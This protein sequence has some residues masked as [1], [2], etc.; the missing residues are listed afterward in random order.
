NYTGIV[1]LASL[2]AFPTLV[3]LSLEY[4]P[5]LSSLAGLESL[6]T[7]TDSLTITNNDALA[8]LLALAQL[9]EVGGDLILHENPGLADLG[10]LEQ[11]GSVGGKLELGG[12]GLFGG[13]V[14]SPTAKPIGTPAITSLAGLTSL[15]HVGGLLIAG[16]ELLVSLDGAPSLITV[17]E[18][19][20]GIHD[21]PMLPPAITQAFV[22]E[23]AVAGDIQVCDQE[24][25]E[26]CYWCISGNTPQ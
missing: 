20:V 3:R 9:S 6:T 1:N 13:E 17:G 21:N 11:L 26:D 8:N 14:D 22:Y 15:A 16:N 4:N 24:G 18:H 12:C 10:G 7:I 25:N 23:L 19:G 5:S 2:P